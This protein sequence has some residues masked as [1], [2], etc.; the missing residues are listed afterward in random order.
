M[1]DVIQICATYS[2]AIQVIRAHQDEKTC[3]FACYK[4]SPS[5]G[6]KDFREEKHTF[7]WEDRKNVKKF[8]IP[9]TGIQFMLLGRLLFDC[10]HGKQRKKPTSSVTNNQ[11]HSYQ[12]HNFSHQPTKKLGCP[13]AICVREIVSFPQY[14]L[15]VQYNYVYKEV[16]LPLKVDLGFDT[17]R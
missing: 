4:K 11:D 15:K 6:D 13:A 16:A 1:A 12:R 8:R 10:E 3:S 2:E 7:V 5:F 17:W 14:K 9:P